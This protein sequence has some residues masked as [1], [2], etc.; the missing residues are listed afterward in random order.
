MLRRSRIAFIVAL[1]AV[2]T[3][4]EVADEPLTGPGFRCD[5]TNPVREVLTPETGLL[6]FRVPIRAADTLHVPFVVTGRFGQ[7]RTDVPVTFT[8][9]DTTIL[10]VDALGVVRPRTAGTATITVAS[11]GVESEIEI[12][13]VSAVAQT[14][15]TPSQR[16]LIV[17]DSLVVA[18][19]A[20]AHT[21]AP[22]TDVDFTWSASSAAVQVTRL[23]DTAAVAKAV[24][25]GTATVTATGEGTT[26]SAA[27]TVVNLTFPA[28]ASA[29]QSGIA[30][31]LGYT[32][33]IANQVGRGFCWGLGQFD[34]LGTSVSSDTTCYSDPDPLQ[35]N[36]LPGIP[37]EQPA[38]CYLTPRRTA[39]V[40]TFTSIAA[41][42]S[43]V[44]GIAAGGRLYCWG[45][46]I[47]GNRGL[48][49]NGT[50]QGSR[51]PV[52]VT[53]SLTFT[54]VSVGGWHACG[55]SGTAAYCWGSDSVGQLGDWRRVH[56]TT[57]IPVMAD[58][59]TNAVLP[60]SQI[61]AGYEHT[62]GLGPDGSAYCWGES[63]FGRLGVTA[64]DQ[65]RPTALGARF[66]QISAG[67][68]HTCA[69]GSDGVYC[70]GNND[71]GQ[72]GQPTS[73]PVISAPTRVT[74]AG[75]VVQVSTGY[76]HTCALT[77]DGRVLCWGSNGDLQ[78]GIGALGGSSSTPLQVA[79]G[80]ATG[81]SFTR[82]TAGYN[83]NCAVG[84]NGRAY[85]WGSN[86]FGALGN[87]LQAAFRGV[88]ILV[89]DPQ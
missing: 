79:A 23:N 81:V 56:S 71:A 19:R 51:V 49:G 25:P 55:I 9:S 24:A 84:N 54:S 1:T 57:P 76:K 72:T 50:R 18:A 27:I 32:C 37:A 33:G 17:G 15:V 65:A 20:I 5:V 38:R 86:V 80:Q 85:C 89:S 52:P 75:T 2:G 48:L 68:Q 69:L 82:L 31:G 53:S 3:S 63:S 7:E 34:Q 64:G 16:T 87:T 73:L 59:A 13:A 22:M 30:A 35:F 47:E 67:G 28:G 43:T 45:G 21:G 83:H 40:P 78:L 6:T 26:G 70:W 61:S 62:C 46:S 60:L 66:S 41:G 12:T 4:C 14:I 58:P 8:S 36:S 88:P 44:C 74:I 77:S 39:E 11:C 42:L 29:T 10:V